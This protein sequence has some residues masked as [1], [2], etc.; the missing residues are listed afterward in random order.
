M[1]RRT[2]TLGRLPC[3]VAGP[4][5]AP[6]LVLLPGLSP[7]HA[8]GRGVAGRA[9]L[10]LA[11]GFAGRFRV[12]WLARRPGLA[13]DASP[14][15]MASLAA[16]VAA[17]LS[18]GF[19]GPV[20]VLGVSTGGSLALQLAAGHPQAVRRLVVVSAAAR[21]G[22][23]ARAEQRALAELIRA[24]DRRS[25]LARIAADAAAGA[26]AP[27]AALAR[28]AL[29]VLGRAAGPLL[30][31]DAG[32]LRDMAAVIDAEDGFDLRDRLAEVWAP[33]LVVAG[34]RDPHY[35]PGAFEL[36]ARGVRDGRLVR[37]GR[38]GHLTV[39]SDPRFATTVSAFLR[40]PSPARPER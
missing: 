6:P 10:G 26:P 29:A 30:W 9:E 34:G 25:A 19:A 28:P 39:V 16:E 21:L 4:P 37:F 15:T 14:A 11:R 40:D 24:G 38:R 13:D 2:G 33:A 36:L 18:E 5:A 20:D 17:A 32:D 3:L 22:E 1:R 27:L 35:D 7:E 23:R 12:T 8:V 31:P